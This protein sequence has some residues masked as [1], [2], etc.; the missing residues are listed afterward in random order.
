MGLLSG[1]KGDLDPLKK[2]ST[3]LDKLLADLPQAE[4]LTEPDETASLP[5]T[6]LE[7]TRRREQT[8]QLLELEGLIANVVKLV[9]QL[10]NDL[11]PALQ[12]LLKDNEENKNC[13][14]GPH[15]VLT[16]NRDAKER[17]YR[18]HKKMCKKT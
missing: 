5:R 15:P 13:F 10:V 6:L 2:L 18:S 16:L 9:K 7:P 12:K 4:T 14:L 17:M 1:L 3:V 8:I 11:L